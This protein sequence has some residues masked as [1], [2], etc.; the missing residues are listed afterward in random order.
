[1]WFKIY[2]IFINWK[3][4]LVVVWTMFGS[5]KKDQCYNRYFVNEYIFHIEEYG[6]GIKTYNSGVCVKGSISNDFEID[7]YEKLE[8]VIEL[9]NYSELDK[10][11]YSNVIGMILEES[12]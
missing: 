11:F 7:Y 9:Q 4:I 5:W 12:E 1:M 10:V 8:E 2:I 6:Q 3:G